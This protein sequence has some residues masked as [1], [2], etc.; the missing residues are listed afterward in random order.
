MSIK[1]LPLVVPWAS[2]LIHLSRE[3]SE[4]RQNLRGNWR[5][6]LVK[7]EKN[8]NLLVVRKLNSEIDVQSLIDQY[9]EFKFS[10]N[11][12]GVPKD[13]LR[14]FITSKFIHNSFWQF[15]CVDRRTNEFYGSILISSSGDTATYLI[16]FSTPAGKKMQVSCL[17]LWSA[18]QYARVNNLAIFDMGGFS[19]RTPKGIT[20]FKS[21][22]NGVK[23]NRP[24]IFW[25]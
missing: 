18:I 23:Y 13:V 4:L 9:E 1:K 19:S 7:A 20:S 10:K 12:D 11:F 5:N 16:G 25:V 6:A 15:S 17:L 21:G 22:L 24:G 14:N 2:S 3:L 8:A